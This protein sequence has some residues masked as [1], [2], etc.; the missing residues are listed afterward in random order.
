M[1]LLTL[2]LLAAAP[3]EDAAARFKREQA[4]LRAALVE[5]CPTKRAEI[6][7]LETAKTTERVDLLR[8]L[9]TC[10]AKLEAYFVTLG[11]ALNGLD[12]FAEA[13]A[14]YRKA[15]ALRVTESAQL[16]L[17][18]ALVRQKSLSPKQK[19]DLD[20]NLG[21]FHAHPCSRDDLCAG[22]CYVAW[23]VED[24]ALTTSSGEKAIALG[25]PGWQPYFL[26]G[27]VYAGGSDTD[28]QR[29]VT[30]LREAKKRGGPANDIDAFLS[31]LGA[32]AEPRSAP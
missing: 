24:H 5:K 28:R 10:A 1:V 3:V 23:H 16:G 9:E 26:A 8:G 14:A 30:L 31:D 32:A 6:A 7:K 20:E 22:L 17:L 2:T 15:L 18:T 4:E 29:A 25:F 19:K 11:G 27:T 13:E 21:Y 12:R